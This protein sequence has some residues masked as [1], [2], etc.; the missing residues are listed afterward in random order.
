LDAEQQQAERLAA[1]TQ[2]NFE[3]VRTAKAVGIPAEGL[4]QLLLEHR[5]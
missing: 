2:A 1:R 4:A 3:R 5:A